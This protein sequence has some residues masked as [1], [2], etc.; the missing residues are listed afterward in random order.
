MKFICVARNYHAHAIEMRSKAPTEPIFFFKPENAHAAQEG[1]FVY[2]GFSQDVHH[3][4]ELVVRM[5]KRCRNV[6]VEEAAGSYD[7]V[8]LGIDFTA[9]DMQAK[10]KESSYPWEAA[11]AFEGAAP[12]GRFIPVADLPKG[13]Q[14]L[15]FELRI[16][17]ELRQKGYTGDMIF[18]VEEII[19]YISRFVTIDPGDLIFTGTPE[20][21]GPV[22][23]GEVLSCTL[24]GEELL[25]V[26]VVRE[27]EK[28]G[29]L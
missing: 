23:V 12:Y 7:A 28:T 16:D 22:Q 15:W 20:G 18:S 25:S 14:D 21:I 2:P 3:E 19:A 10:M 9:R 27:G 26:R 17:G 1:V 29:S 13:M 8:T 6:T 4:I 5:S 11:K 24:E